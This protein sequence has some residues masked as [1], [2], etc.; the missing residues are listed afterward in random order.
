MRM[1]TSVLA[2]LMYPSL[3]R[4]GTMK[5]RA[6]ACQSLLVSVALFLGTANWEQ[7][8]WLLFPKTKED[9]HHYFYRNI[10]QEI[11]TLG[12][13]C[14]TSNR[15]ISQDVI[16]MS[17]TTPGEQLVRRVHGTEGRATKTCGHRSGKGPRR[18]CMRTMATALLIIQCTM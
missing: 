17:Q 12:N 4:A 16:S 5:S 11:D 14:C 7:V 3:F 13:H 1:A 2:N 6:T 8:S 15:L 18:F 9:V 10:I